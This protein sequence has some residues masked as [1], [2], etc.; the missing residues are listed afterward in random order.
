M[1]KNVFNTRQ[2]NLVT[3]NIINLYLVLSSDYPSIHCVRVHSM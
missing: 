2:V 3:H 1:T